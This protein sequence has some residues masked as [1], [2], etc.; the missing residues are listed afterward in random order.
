MKARHLIPI[1]AFT[2]A[3]TVSAREFTDL[4]GRKLEAE[5]TDVTG[6]RATLKR[7]VDGRSFSV[8]IASF[9]PED[10]K[11]MKAYGEA[12]RKYKF[13]VRAEKKKTG[14]K[15]VRQ[16]GLTGKIEQWVYEINLRNLSPEPASGLTAS[17]WVFVKEMAEKGRQ[18]ARPEAKGVQVLKEMPFNG[19]CT[20]TTNYVNIARVR[21][22]PG[23]YIDGASSKSDQMAGLVVRIYKDKRE[24]FRYATD[25]SLLAYE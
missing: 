20:L 16:G 8:E 10:Q 13:D 2:F 3:I 12:N 19:T 18:P 15:D 11:F 23:Y 25:N 14:D 24:V 7:A 17:Y 22:A 1:C 6:A 5:L 21:A 4:Q 9:S